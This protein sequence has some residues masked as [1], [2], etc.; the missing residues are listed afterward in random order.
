MRD[1]KLSR[2]IKSVIFSFI[3]VILVTSLNLVLAT[4]S[5]DDYKK[6]SDLTGDDINDDYQKK[7]SRN[8]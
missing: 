3:I 6:T 8:Y 4:T 7:L 1:I 5:N 2:L